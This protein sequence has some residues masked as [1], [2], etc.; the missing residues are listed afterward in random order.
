MVL[1]VM[2]F[3]FWGLCSKLMLGRYR[4]HVCSSCVCHTDTSTHA[5]FNCRA[6]LFHFA[7]LRLH[8]QPCAIM[9]QDRLLWRV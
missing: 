9:L 7:C 6:T 5:C 3:F 2:S 8:V 1:V 4:G